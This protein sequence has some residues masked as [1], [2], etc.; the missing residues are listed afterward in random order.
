M[1]RRDARTTLCSR[2]VTLMIVIVQ[3]ML[4][5]TLSDADQDTISATDHWLSCVATAAHYRHLGSIN[6]VPT[7]IIDGEFLLSPNDHCMS[8][9]R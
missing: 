8:F 7:T 6:D 5:T 4:V 2:L 1:S 9:N 3:L